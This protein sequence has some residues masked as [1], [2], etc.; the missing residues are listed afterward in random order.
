GIAAFAFGSLFLAPFLMNLG[1]MPRPTE[2]HE[3]DQKLPIGYV[4]TGV[5]FYML[6]ST[7]LASLPSAT[8]I[9]ATGQQLIVVGVGL[10]CWQ[11]WRAGNARKLALWIGV[12]LSFPFITIVTRGFIGYGAGAAVCVLIFVS[13]FV[14][15]HIRV[16][17]VALIV[18]YLG[19]SIFT[20]Y[21]R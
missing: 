21:M 14:R 20:T 18:S 13:S 5:V 7:A 19:L 11:A 2:A 1:L 15:S 16:T 9:I 8:A 6:L 12:A 10:S 3:P 4:C 17:A